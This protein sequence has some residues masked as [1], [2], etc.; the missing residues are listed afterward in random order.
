MTRLE[1]RLAQCAARYDWPAVTCVCC[2]QTTPCLGAWSYAC[3]YRGLAGGGGDPCPCAA[4]QRGLS[5]RALLLRLDAWEA[6]RL[7]PCLHGHVSQ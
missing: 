7:A 5:D 3:E 1:A 6:E 2:L 4:Y